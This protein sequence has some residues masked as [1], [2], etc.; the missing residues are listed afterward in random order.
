MRDFTVNEMQELKK[1][2]EAEVLLAPDSNELNEI[3][4]LAKNKY[5]IDN[6]EANRWKQAL[7]KSKDKRGDRE[8]GL[9]ISKAKLKALDGY[10]AQ[11]KNVSMSLR[12]IEALMKAQ[13]VEIRDRIKKAQYHSHAE[14]VNILLKAYTII[15][16]SIQQINCFRSSNSLALL[17]IG[18]GV[19]PIKQCRDRQYKLNEP[20]K[21]LNIKEKK[22]QVAVETMNFLSRLY[23]E[24]PTETLWYQLAEVYLE[25]WKLTHTHC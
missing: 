21:L 1:D 8:Q 20:R 25:I 7:S 19:F 14:E 23:R 9:K 17:A 18:K 22:L 24:K 6:K 10:L 16:N 2:I 11:G 12:D 13:I 5:Y 15:E 3:L 4:L